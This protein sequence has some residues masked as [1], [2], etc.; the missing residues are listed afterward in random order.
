MKKRLK[1]LIMVSALLCLSLAAVASADSCTKTLYLDGAYVGSATDGNG[2]MF[3]NRHLKLGVEGPPNYVYN[4]YCGEMS[5]FAIYAGSLSA[6]RIM[7][8]YDA[9]SNGNNYYNAVHADNPLLWLRFNDAS[10]GEGAT[11]ANSG[12]LTTMHGVYTMTDSVLFSQISGGGIAGDNA[13]Q[14]PRAQT[15]GTGSFVDVDDSNGQLS[16]NLNGNVTIELWIDCNASQSANFPR[17]F[18]HNGGN[19]GGVTGG[20]LLGAYGV[21][22]NNHNQLAITG[23]GTVDY[24]TTPYDV[25]DGNWHQI[26]VTYASTYGPQPPVVYKADGTYVGEVNADN[27]VLWLRFEAA[28]PKDYS[29]A[30]GNHW[31]GYGGAAS[32]VS[33]VGGIGNSV[34]VTWPGSM[35][36][37]GY[38]SS[39]A[40]AATNNPNSPPEVNTSYEVFDNK[41][42]FVPGPNSIS[43]EIWVKA[44]PAGQM[45]MHHYGVFFQQ[46]G[47][48]S[49]INHEPNGPFLSNSD[50][51][52]RIG[53]GNQ[54]W[55]CDVPSPASEDW[56][57]LVPY[58]SGDWGTGHA[59]DYNW[60]QLVV[61]YDVNDPNY[62][63]APNLFM[64][65]YLDGKLI[66]WF[67]D[68]GGWLGG[69][70]LSHMLLG[71]ENDM[72][73][74]YNVFAGDMDE[75]AI[76]AGVL[77][78]DRVRAHYAAW[79]PKSCAE[80]QT[81]GLGLPGD[82]DGNCKIN[83]VDLAIFA[84]Q[85]RKC[86]DPSGSCPGCTPSSC[87][88]WW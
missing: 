28:S 35:P 34:M 84:S 66:T 18:Q 85:W 52:L 48:S 44:P 46:I 14:F 45:Q 40:V 13:L 53:A 81:R 23:G 75:F 50:G 58:A 20:Y 88:P 68:P 10:V 61:T 83:F 86:N 26:V 39:Y 64:Q 37:G 62:G 8:H 80:M 15:D 65:L 31:V 36:S 30:D 60:H 55:Y 59:A 6:A 11:A 17:L 16:T 33:K 51:Q 71:S 43:F 5:E 1:S 82:M 7:A 54:F 4:Q 25:N 63:P 72:G 79:Q 76:Y 24:I 77:G 27:P 38:S 22:I 19:G 42:A 47:S 21:D 2:L 70:C 67:P 57:T 56:Y 41:Y 78:A 69:P 49:G 29:A 74:S 9:N 3:L 87:P 32:I 73:N 12:S